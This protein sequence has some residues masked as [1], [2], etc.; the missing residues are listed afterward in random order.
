MST[1]KT[2]INIASTDLFPTPMN[3]TF[4]VTETIGGAHSS[5]NTKVLPAAATNVVLFSSNAASGSTGILYFCIQAS[6]DNLGTISVDIRRGTGPVT[7]D[8]M[9]FAP[10]DIAYFPVDASDP[11]GVIIRAT[12]NAGASI[13]ALQYFYGEKG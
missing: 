5:F 7:A 1:L 2:T 13:A 9:L 10:G 4:P 3:F 8:V 6:A 11:L 12:N